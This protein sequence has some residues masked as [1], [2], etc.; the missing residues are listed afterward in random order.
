MK[1]TVGLFIFLFFMA[2][3]MKQAENKFV[4]VDGENPPSEY[5]HGET[6]N[7]ASVSCS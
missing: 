5:T 4:Q 1:Y 7:C 6:S 2:C 3:Q